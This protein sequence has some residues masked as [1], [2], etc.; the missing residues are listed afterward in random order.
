MSL[1]D[2]IVAAAE[3]QPADDGTH[4]A[5]LELLGLARPAVKPVAAPAPAPVPPAPPPPGL[6]PDSPIPPVPT[7]TSAAQPLSGQPLPA[8]VSYKSGLTSRPPAWATAGAALPRAREAGSPAPLPGILGRLEGRG[9]YTAALSTWVDEGEPDLDRAVNELANY[10]PLRQ[11][12]R[13][14]LRTLRRGVQLLLDTGPS[15]APY[16]MD[17]HALDDELGTLLSGSQME[18]WYFMRCPIRGVRES[19][20][21]RARV[22]PSPPRGMPVLA[23]SDF[24][25]ADNLNDEDAASVAEWRRFAGEVRA[26]GHPLIGLV[27]FEP[28]RWPEPLAS[29]I[30]LIHWS[31][32]TIAASVERVVREAQRR[33][34]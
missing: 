3:L 7:P 30:T 29:A 14:P 18:R 13:L 32:R 28:R 23:V 9:I 16:A 25:I 33:S 10:R 22:W 2:K 24:G 19:L 26:E 31:E 12:P 20:R 1:R 21:S 11:L 6:K 34:P 17:V 5:I 4:D 27:P 15:M 8:Q